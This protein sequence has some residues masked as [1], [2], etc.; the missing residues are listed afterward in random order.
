MLVSDLANQQDGVAEAFERN[1]VDGKRLLI[2]TEEELKTRSFSITRLGRRKNIIRAIN[3][4]KANI[5]RS[6]NNGVSMLHSGGGDHEP[7]LHVNRSAGSIR[8]NL[9]RSNLGLGS[10]DRSVILSNA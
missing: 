5:C 10:I 4:L 2:L 3:L 9:N 7:E 8:L 1:R 6:I